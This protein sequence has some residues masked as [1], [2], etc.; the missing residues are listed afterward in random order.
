MSPPARSRIPLSLLAA[1]ILHAAGLLVVRV[2]PPRPLELA[3]IGH[4]FERSP[5]L[6]IDLRPTEP[7]AS[8]PP[9][10][11]LETPPPAPE[12]A[13]RVAVLPQRT[14]PEGEEPE[15]VPPAPDAPPPS[16]PAPSTTGP[17]EYDG[18]PGEPSRAG[19]L[20]GPPVWAVPGAMPREAAPAPAP[21][22]PTA[23]GVL[24]GSAEQAKFPAAGTLASA[25]AEQ[26]RSSSTPPESDSTFLLTL[27]AR[28]QIASVEVVVAKGGDRKEWERIARAVK[29]KFA[30]RVFPMPTAYAGGGRVFV[31]TRSRLTMPD[32]TA[33]GIPNPKPALVG[34]N[35][36]IITLPGVRD[37][38][39]SN[40]MA[41]TDLPPDAVMIGI[42]FDFDVANIGAKRRRVVHT[43]VH[44]EPI[45]AALPPPAA[46]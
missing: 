46:P 15:P 16:L 17:A 8:S 4:A 19:T 9:R 40:P 29:E 25:V 18:P 12:P 42:R 7:A 20:A 1:L 3:T 45:G 5:E 27:D 35:S 2:L 14:T 11:A 23:Q 36:S 24:A 39:L 44:A 10:G 34:G 43:Q 30:G 6:W 33:H 21:I 28:G 22:R 41:S 26:I 31:S 32:G 13:P 38:R 37:D